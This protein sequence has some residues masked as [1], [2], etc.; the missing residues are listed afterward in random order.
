MFSWL[1]VSDNLSLMRTT[2]TSYSQATHC[3]TFGEAY[4]KC[5]FGFGFQAAKR[6]AREKLAAAPDKAE[7]KSGDEPQGGGSTFYWY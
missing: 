5:V 2:T 3:Y 1:L 7:D 4:L 6:A